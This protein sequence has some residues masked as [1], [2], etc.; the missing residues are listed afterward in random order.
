[1]TVVVP[2]N[3][4]TAQEYQDA[5][6]KS[7]LMPAAATVATAV[8]DS[9][10]AKAET[11]RLKI[12][13]PPVTA[14]TLADA[15]ALGVAGN[16][17][18]NNI[19]QTVEYNT[20][21]GIG[22]NTY[23]L[24]DGGGSRP[25]EN[26]G[27]IIH[28]GAGDL[29]LKGMFDGG[30]AKLSQFG[31]GNGV[32]AE[33]SA[34]AQ[35]II[36][37]GFSTCF[38]ENNTNNYELI[39]LVIPPRVT[40]NLVGESV[41]G[42]TVALRGKIFTYGELTGAATEA[43]G[44]VGNFTA[45]L[46]NDCASGI[47]EYLFCRNIK[48]KPIE[49]IDTS[50]GTKIG[51]AFKFDRS[52]QATFS[53]Q[54]GNCKGLAL[55]EFGDSTNAEVLDTIDLG[56]TVWHANQCI[57]QREGATNVHGILFSNTKMR[58]Y[59]YGQEHT[60]ANCGETY[61]TVDAAA[62]ST[63]LTV[64]DAS[65]LRQGVLA[66]G[67]LIYIGFGHNAEQVRLSGVPVANVIPL[68]TPTRFAHASNVTGS[69]PAIGEPVIY[70]PVHVTMQDVSSMAVGNCHAER[71]WKAFALI[72][73]KGFNIQSLF[74]TCRKTL[75]VARGC[76]AMQINNISMGNLGWGA[77]D[78]IEIM[79]THNPA[80]FQPNIK[81]NRQVIAEDSLVVTYVNNQ[82][83]VDTS[84]MVEYCGGIAQNLAYN[85]TLV[86][87]TPEITTEAYIPMTGDI[88]ELRILD[89]FVKGQRL[90][91]NFKKDSNG[92]RKIT[93]I[94]TNVTFDEPFYLSS[95]PFAKDEL[96]LM[97]DGTNWVEVS[98]LI[99]D[100]A[101]LPREINFSDLSNAGNGI[102]TKNKYKG[103]V[104]FNTS[105]NVRFMATGSATTDTWINFA[106]GGTIVPA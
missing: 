18:A 9:G 67:D 68:A 102:N 79:P 62:G 80:G 40:F 46:Y 27:S 92:H 65:Q 106:A 39:N 76:E 6:E 52:Y 25:A 96:S 83:T 48:T 38:L 100:Q 44:H 58:D 14:Q 35:A 88:T 61:L 37:A 30:V 74:S 59:E 5:L 13:K 49:Y 20:S 69:S 24:I 17:L 95:R 66:S 8:S 94:N 63:S 82:S 78:L 90:K 42:V 41:E 31:G 2:I 55:L 43:P 15:I 97:W 45:K 7:Y 1:M 71:G 36:D 57:M 12:T 56:D 86:K 10:S 91:L 32:Q 54:F 11:D 22:G 16:A 29:Y 98:R 23:Q 81:I 104:V 70:G 73:C 60:V 93:T 84:Q 50:S 105:A 87:V 103:K 89:G 21:T 85:A 3:V 19:I 51:H 4:T 99:Y 53:G 72:N 47:F 33:D 28:V 34:A 75:S 101:Y 26:G 64:N 77:V